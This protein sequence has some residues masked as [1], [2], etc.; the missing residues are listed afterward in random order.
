VP[1]EELLR[2]SW[3]DAGFVVPVPLALRPHIRVIRV[4]QAAAHI[5][6]INPAFCYVVIPKDAPEPDQW[7]V[8]VENGALKIKPPR[9]QRTGNV[10]NIATGN[11]RVGMQVGVVRGTVN[12]AGGRVRQPQSHVITI[13]LVLPRQIT[14]HDQL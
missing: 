9:E 5:I 13:G 1:S 3:K 6:Q 11:A 10:T 4:K 12:I 8:T 14:V 7:R 2:G